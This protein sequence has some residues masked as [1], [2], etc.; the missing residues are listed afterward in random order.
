MTA[1]LGERWEASSIFYKPY[2]ANHFTHTAIDAAVALRGQGLRPED[3]AC[4]TLE[5]APPTVRTIGEPIAAKR[6]PNTGYDA[7]FSGPYAVAAGLLGGGGLGVS[8]DDFSDD[9]A[10]DP[11]RREL[12]ARIDVVGD[13]GLMD[14]YPCQL[15]ARLTVTTRDGATLVSEVLTN[16]GGPDRPLS[17]DELASKY[18]DNTAGLLPDD[19]ARRTHEALSGVLTADSVRGLLA[20]L[21]SLP[22]M[23]DLR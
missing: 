23:E 3:I 4:A 19:A 11:H 14:I 1:E 17:E 6:S 21:A 16:R 18:F 9:L 2:P 8:L 12:M 7:Q 15:P 10:R 5:V 22:H 20:P 13:P